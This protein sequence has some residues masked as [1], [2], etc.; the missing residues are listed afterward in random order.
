M[1]SSYLS[2]KYPKNK[3]S[4]NLKIRLSK[5]QAFSSENCKTKIAFVFIILLIMRE[6]SSVLSGY[7][8]LQCKL[9]CAIKYIG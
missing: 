4:L 2:Y 8:L 6:R 7:K 9:L 1:K 3:E 5:C